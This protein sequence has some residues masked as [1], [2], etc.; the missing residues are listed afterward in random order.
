MLINVEN[1]GR[2]VIEYI[3]EAGKTTILFLDTFTGI[4]SGKSNIRLILDQMVKIGIDSIPIAITSAFFVG[5]VFAVQIATEFV[6][7]GAGKYIGGVMGIAVARELAPALTGIVISSRVAASITAEIGTMKVTEQIEALNSL[8]SNPIKY[9]VI[10]R[11]LACIFMMPL[12]TILSDICSFFGGYFVSVYL[13]KINS[14][15]YLNSAQQLLKYNDIYGGIFKSFIFGIIISIIAC[16]KGLN[17]KGGAKG[18]GE[19]TTSSVVASLIALFIVNY[20]LSVL[21]FK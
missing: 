2:L 18:V 7:F 11:F 19:A 12:L 1:L 9:L 17:T 15:D 21:L 14:V 4:F 8:G 16:R 13:I 3:E 10:P 5:M 6:K 20:F